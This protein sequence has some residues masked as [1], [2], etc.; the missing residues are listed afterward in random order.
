MTNE[1]TDSVNP[2]AESENG[3]CRIVKKRGILLIVLLFVVG[4]VFLAIGTLV[5]LPVVAP[6]LAWRTRCPDMQEAAIPHLK[7][8]LHIGMTYNEMVEVMGEPDGAGRHL[9]K[10]GREFYS[11][12]VNSWYNRGID[13]TLK[14]GRIIDIF[15]YD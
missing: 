14:G 4:I 8:R 15:E 1:M 11:Y 3:G 5:I 12:N 2:F 7:K 9:Q 13:I 10:D 6:S